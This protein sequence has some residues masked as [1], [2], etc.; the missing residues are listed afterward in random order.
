MRLLR[1]LLTQ[2][3]NYTLRKDL[4]TVTSRFLSWKRFSQDIK[5]FSTQVENFFGW[6]IFWK[7][8]KSTQTQFYIRPTK[9]IVF[10]QTYKNLGFL[11]PYTRNLYHIRKKLLW[12]IFDILHNKWTHCD[13][14]FQTCSKKFCSLKNTWYSSYI[15]PWYGQKIASW[16]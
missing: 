3:K 1:A 15:Y 11:A 9:Y 8:N 13:W 4:E 6:R 12:Q 10:G 14:A 5:I 2:K 7:R 16:A